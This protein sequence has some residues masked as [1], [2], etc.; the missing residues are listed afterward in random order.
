MRDNRL[1]ILVNTNRHPEYVWQ[2]ANAAG[3]LQKQ[4]HVHFFDE[5]LELVDHPALAGLERIAEVTLSP[6]ARVA[7]KITDSAAANRRR[8]DLPAFFQSCGRCLVF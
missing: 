1:C 4:V 6:D 2:L 8:I 5:G 3:R 7:A